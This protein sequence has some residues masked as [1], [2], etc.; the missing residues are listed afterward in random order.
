MNTHYFHFISDYR[1]VSQWR[2]ALYAKT[3]MNTQNF[4]KHRSSDLSFL[5]FARKQIVLRLH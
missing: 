1:H 4:A 2:S 5:L 3:Q